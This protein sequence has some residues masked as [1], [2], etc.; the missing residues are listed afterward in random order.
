MASVLSV[1]ARRLKHNFWVCQFAKHHWSYLDDQHSVLFQSR[2]YWHFVLFGDSYSLD[3]IALSVIRQCLQILRLFILWKIK[4]KSI[5][6]HQ[7]NSLFDIC[8]MW[9]DEARHLLLA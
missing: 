9:Q 7:V 4:S 8:S 3:C 6:E 2:I 5:F 1:I